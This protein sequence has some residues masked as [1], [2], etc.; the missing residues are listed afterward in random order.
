VAA[1]VDR[2]ERLTSMITEFLDLPMGDNRRD[3]SA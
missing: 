1:L 3:V 2:T